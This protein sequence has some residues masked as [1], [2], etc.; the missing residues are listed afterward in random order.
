[1]CVQCATHKVRAHVGCQPRESHQPEWSPWP[2]PAVV[3]SISGTGSLHVGCPLWDYCLIVDL[4]FGG[5]VQERCNSS[6][7]AVELHLS[8][9]NLLIQLCYDIM[10]CITQKQE[11]CHADNF[12][13]ANFV[14]YWLDDNL[15]CSE[16]CKTSTWQP[17]HFKQKIQQYSAWWKSKFV[18]VP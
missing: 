17:Y 3:A 13:F 2:R 7:L 10:D 11:S 8:C 16:W 15:W 5:I 18:S 1:M 4:H 6:A 12:S 14:G 9:T